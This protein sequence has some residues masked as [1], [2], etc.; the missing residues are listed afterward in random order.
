VN[1]IGQEK[2]EISEWQV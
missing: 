1:S 2:V